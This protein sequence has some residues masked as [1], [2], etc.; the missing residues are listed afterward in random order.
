MTLKNIFATI[1]FA[2]MFASTFAN[3]SKDD[4]TTRISKHKKMVITSSVVDLLKHPGITNEHNDNISFPILAKDTAHV[5]QMLFGERV[6]A[7][8]DVSDWLEIR[9]VEQEVF[10]PETG[11]TKATGWIHKSQAYIVEKFPSYNIA[12]TAPWTN[13]Y[14]LPNEGSKLLV[15]VCAGTKLRG[16]KKSDDKQW[17]LLKLPN[18][19]GGAIK[20]CDV[21]IKHAKGIKPERKFESLRKSIVLTAKNFLGTP[22]CFGGRS[23]YCKD[24]SVKKILG[25][26]CSGLVNLS[27]RANGFAIPRTSH[28]QFLKSTKIKDGVFQKL[29]PADLI[30]SASKRNPKQINHVMMYA[31]N[32][33]II[34]ATSN[35]GNVRIID[36][37]KRLG[38]NLDAIKYGHSTKKT[39]YYFGSIL[40]QEDLIPTSTRIVV[41]PVTQAASKKHLAV[42]KKKLN[43]NNNKKRNR[44]K[45]PK[46]IKKSK[47]LP[48]KKTCI[49]NSKRIARAGAASKPSINKGK[50]QKKYS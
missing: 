45:Q 9:A 50:Q 30:F 31:G 25:V 42:A 10:T 4:A 47:K 46:K 22:Y 39:V 5:T 28:A 20:N 2:M 34:E 3:V 11:W 6:I 44:I 48:P 37:A 33:Q 27:Y 16:Y 14:S 29:K 38:L 7:L 35:S 19:K 12:V 15:K 49:H 36:A 41:Q 24:T 43:K 17:I 1:I 26:D 40:D 21:C 8:K 32:G 23:M 13:I 18:Q